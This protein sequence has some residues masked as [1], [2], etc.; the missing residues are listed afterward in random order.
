MTF[1]AVVPVSNVSL[2]PW[3]RVAGSAGALADPAAV[4]VDAL[5]DDVELFVAA[6]ATP[7]APIATPVMAAA[8]MSHARARL[9]FGSGVA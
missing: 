9:R 2:G 1:S 4:L 5:V 3:L 7:A 6:P 8:V